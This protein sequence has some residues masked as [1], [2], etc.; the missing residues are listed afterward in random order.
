MQNYS[1][2]EGLQYHLQLRRGDVGE[3]VILPGDPKRCAKIAEHFQDSRLMAECAIP[4][5]EGQAILRLKGG[6]GGHSPLEEIQDDASKHAAEFI[7]QNCSRVLFESDG[8]MDTVTVVKQLEGA[9][10]LEREKRV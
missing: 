2:E 3:Y 10:T 1:G 7:V 6:F 8:T 4:Q 9:G 5:E